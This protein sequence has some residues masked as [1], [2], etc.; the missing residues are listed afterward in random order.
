VKAA[1]LANGVRGFRADFLRVRGPPP[2]APCG[3]RRPPPLRAIYRLYPLCAP[4]RR[5]L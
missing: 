4:R 5:G 1:E 3:P 2:A